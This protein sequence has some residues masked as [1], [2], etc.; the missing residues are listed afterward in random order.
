[1]STSRSRILNTGVRGFTLIELLV[2]IAIIAV[3]IA[4]L[5]PAVQQAR[6]AARRSQCKNNLKQIGLALHNYESTHGCFP[7]GTVWDQPDDDAQ[8]GRRPNVAWTLLIAPFLEMAP[9][10]NLIQPGVGSYGTGDDQSSLGRALQDIDKRNALEKPVPVF[11]CPSDIGAER[12]PQY[13]VFQTDSPITRVEFPMCNYV[14]NNGAGKLWPTIG[15][16]PASGQVGNTNRWN[17]GMFGAIGRGAHLTRS[18]HVMPNRGGLCVRIRD[19]SD[20]LSNTVA[21]GERAYE[22]RGVVYGASNAWC[23]KGSHWWACTNVT[24]LPTTPPGDTGGNTTVGLMTVLG[25]GDNV[26][27]PPEAINTDCQ[28]I[29]RHSFASTHDGGVQFV[30]GDGSVRFISENIDASRATS[31]FAVANFRVYSRILGID[32]GLATGE[33]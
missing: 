5:L 18:T 23:Q 28:R 26:M 24:N 12:N 31:N 2:V 22:H 1:M 8:Y 14:A 11:R 4:L 33:F 17:N 29:G 21:V 6:E 7:P 19:V 30:M 27:N 25:G 13:P 20:G 15:S 10:Y 3:L 16:I 9:I 32:E